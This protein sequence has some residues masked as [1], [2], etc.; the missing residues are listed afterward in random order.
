GNDD[1]VRFRSSDAITAHVPRSAILRRTP[2]MRD[3]VEARGPGRSAAGGE[4]AVA[5][6]EDEAGAAL[7]GTLEGSGADEHEAA[8]AEIGERGGAVALAGREAALAH[9]AAL[10]VELG[11]PEFGGFVAAV[12]G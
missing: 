12:A 7:G 5:V 1:V 9:R 3:R 10:R 6:D 4:L 2:T 11:E 8:I